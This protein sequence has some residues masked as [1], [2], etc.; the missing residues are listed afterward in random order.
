[1]KKR[2]PRK[3]TRRQFVKG[4]IGVGLTAATAGCVSQTVRKIASVEIADEYDYVVVGSGA[5]GGPVAVNLARAGYRV[6][7]LEAGNAAP[8]AQRNYEIPAMHPRSVEDPNMRWDFFVKHYKGQENF[9]ADRQD[10]KW[11]PG[12][13]VLYPRAGTLGGCTAHN[14]MITLYPDNQDFDNIAK[15]FGDSSWTGDR[16]R[17]YYQRVEKCQGVQNAME[18]RRG[19]SGWLSVEQNDLVLR[20]KDMEQDMWPFHSLAM[21]S[22]G[23]ESNYSFHR[24]GMLKDPNDWSYVANGKKDGA[25]NLPKATRGGKRNGTRELILDALKKY[26]NLTLSQ[27]SLASKVIL[28]GPEQRAVAVEF[29]QGEHLYSADPMSSPGFSG[30]KRRVK[31]K[32][33]V[34]LSGGAFNSPQLLLLSGIGAKEKLAPFGIEQRVNLSGVGENLQDRYE[35]GVVSKMKA[36]FKVLENCDGGSETDACVAEFYKDPT[37]AIYSSNGPI[38]AMI[39]R[40]SPDLPY[41]D[42]CVFAVPGQFHGYYPGWADDAYVKDRVTWAV[43]KGHTH[44]TSGTVSLKSANPLDTPD[45]NFNYFNDAQLGDEDL[46]AVVAG[47]QMA[48]GINDK[49]MMNNLMVGEEMPKLG[50]QALRDFVKREAWGHHASCSNKMALRGTHNA[51][52]DNKFQVYGTKGLRVVDA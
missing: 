35:V 25:F 13:G 39:K 14:A 16:M 15:T 18:Q 40:S 17:S 29:L 31:V 27:D 12:K 30:I 20:L 44:N 5:G 46:K 41:P 42:L 52:L 45:I 50:G 24:L 36:P 19:T 47:I 26:P 11:V 28:D 23:G 4:T 21:A 10:S 7:L 32:R 3:L 22:A 8:S 49:V 37:S 1:M 2:K 38:T 51:V 9:A 34:I 48:R 6:L 43:L 33:E